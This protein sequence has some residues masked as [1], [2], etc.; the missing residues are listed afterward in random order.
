MTRYLTILLI[1]VSCSQ[2]SPLE[3]MQPPIIVIQKDTVVVVED[4]N[5]RMHTLTLPEKTFYGIA[6]MD[7][8]DTLK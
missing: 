2:P 4:K 6:F 7:I 1:L 5:G 8:E 3:L